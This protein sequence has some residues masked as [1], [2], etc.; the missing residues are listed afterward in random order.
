M[1]ELKIDYPVTV[2]VCKS[3][4]DLDT[5][6]SIADTFEIEKPEGIDLAANTAH[7]PTKQSIGRRT[8]TK[9]RSQLMIMRAF[10]KRSGMALI[11][12]VTPKN[13]HISKYEHNKFTKVF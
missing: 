5:Q 2:A 1:Q 3:E 10:V 8:M 4:T 12:D 7:H 9:M 13:H 6:M 11:K